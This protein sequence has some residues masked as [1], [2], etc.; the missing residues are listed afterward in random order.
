MFILGIETTGKIGSVAIVDE[1][2]KKYSWADADGVA[3]DDL[4]ASFDTSLKPGKSVT[5]QLLFDVPENSSYT[6]RM[7]SSD[8]GQKVEI[9][10]N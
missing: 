8:T 5:G 1:S 4:F 3:P 10:L 6:F 7:E 2:G 9:P